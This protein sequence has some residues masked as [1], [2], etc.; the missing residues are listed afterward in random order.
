MKIG[1]AIKQFRLEMGA[2]QEAIALEAGTFAG[3]LSKIERGQQLPSLDL[4]EKLAVALGAR[5]SDLYAL[6]E[7]DLSDVP[8]KGSQGNEYANAAI[9]L[10]RHFLTL[11]NANKHLAV[12]LLKTMNRVQG[13]GS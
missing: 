9:L 6:A 7:S 4:L 5:V 13:E 8:S 10:R 3:N 1:A 12:E 2:T 11:T